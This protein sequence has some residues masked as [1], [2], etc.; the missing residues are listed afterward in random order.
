MV[1][2]A[3]NTSTWEAEPKA[4]G[5]LSLSLAWSTEKVPRQQGIYREILSPKPTKNRKTK[6]NK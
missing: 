3:C 5:S 1:A 4:G 2:H 6:T